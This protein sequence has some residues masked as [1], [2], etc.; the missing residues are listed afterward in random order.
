VS[1]GMPVYNEAR[2]IDASLGSLRQQDYP[3]LEIVVC[4]NASSD[5]TVSICERHARDDARV[6]I[7]RADRNVGAIANFQRALDESKG[8]YF[9]WAAGHDLWSPDLISACTALLQANDKACVAFGSSCWID[10][11]GA[12]LA[13]AS[14]W[15][16]TRGMDPLA[17]FFTVFWGNMHPVLGVMRTADLRACTPLHQLTGG[18][19]VL[20]SRL[21]L[22]GDFLHATPA[23]WSRREFRTEVRYE[24]KLRRYASTDVAI[25]RSPLQR[26]FPLLQLPFALM[27]VLWRS[28]LP[29]LDRMGALLALMVAFPLRYRVG[30]RDNT[31]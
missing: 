13:R 7:V 12:L 30:R 20:L 15:S 4:D 19:L 3:N 10:A 17:R 14:G 9:M 28:D 6:R 31:R 21:S 23:L 27:G 25:A 16:D 22:R 11:D 5:D 29:W 24:D 2:F 1:I 8:S 18:D 26:V